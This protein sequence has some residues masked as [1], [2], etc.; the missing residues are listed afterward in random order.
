LAAVPVDAKYGA[1]LVFGAGSVLD[2]L[3]DAAP[4]EALQTRFFLF[5]DFVRTEGCFRCEGLGI[6]IQHSHR[7]QT[8]M[9]VY[10]GCNITV[11]TTRNT[12]EH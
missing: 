3:L 10:V 2:F 1:L 5:T 11:L 6:T 9:F 8:T 12:T 7:Q 4:E